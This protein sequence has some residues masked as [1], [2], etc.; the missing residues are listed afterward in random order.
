MCGCV[1][2]SELRFTR[3][4]RQNHG[5]HSSYKLLNTQNE[6][7]ALKTNKQENTTFDIQGPFNAIMEH[8]AAKSLAKL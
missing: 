6:N 3:V 8:T 4:H 7:Q 2:L 1:H 5:F